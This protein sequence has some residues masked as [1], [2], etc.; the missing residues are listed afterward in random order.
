MGMK[1]NNQEKEMTTLADLDS[2]VSVLMHNKAV[3]L[4][5]V[6]QLGPCDARGSAAYGLDLTRVAFIWRGKRRSRIYLSH[7]P[8][9]R[10]AS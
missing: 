2:G 1:N 4:D 10:L 5:E 7:T 8:V 6:D 9:E 3:Q